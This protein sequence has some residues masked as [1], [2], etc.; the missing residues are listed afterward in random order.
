M[1]I[2]KA[3]SD[4]LTSVATSVPSGPKSWTLELVAVAPLMRPENATLISLSMA[5][6]PPIARYAGD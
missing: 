3:S 5:A 6:P 4:A 2:A 1:S